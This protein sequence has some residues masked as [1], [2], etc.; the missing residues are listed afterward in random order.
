M[1]YGVWSARGTRLRVFQGRGKPKNAGSRVVKALT[2]ERLGRDVRDVEHGGDLVQGDGATCQA[3][4]HHGVLGGEPAG[5]ANEA[6][7]IGAVNDGFGVGEDR[8]GADGADA[9]V[10]FF[11]EQKDVRTAIAYLRAVDVTLSSAAPG[12]S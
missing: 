8:R 1:N 10:E 9:A 12:L 5:G 11:L 3:P 2:R 7:A 4:A 6:S